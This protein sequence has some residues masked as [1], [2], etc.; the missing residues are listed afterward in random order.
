MKRQVRKGLPLF[1]IIPFKT[2]RKIMKS[3]GVRISSLRSLKILILALLP[4]VLTAQ[5]STPEDPPELILLIRA[6]EQ[7]PNPAELVD[8]VER[9]SGLPE[10]MDVGDPIGGK[11][12]LPR[13]G[14]PA[15]FRGIATTSPDSPEGRLGR[16]IVFEYPPTADFAMIAAT[17]R[18]HPHVEHVE[19]NR[20]ITLSS[21]PVGATQRAL[22]SDPLL[23][24]A[25]SDPT[26]FQ[27]GTH[28][29]NLP[30]AWDLTTGHATIGLLDLGLQPD[31]PDLRTYGEA[32]GGGLLFE[33]GNFREHRSQDVFFDDCNVDE[34]DPNDDGSETNRAGH[35]THVAG[36]AAATTDNREGIAGSCPGCGLHVMKVFSRGSSSTVQT[37][38]GL[39]QLLAQGAQIASMS[40]GIDETPCQGAS[41]LR[42]LCQFIA[43]ANRRGML[44]IASSG[45]DR[46]GVEFPAN[47]EAVV[48][49][50]GASYDVGGFR[51]WDFCPSG[52]PSDPNCICPLSGVPG[53]DEFIECGSNFGPEQ[54][55][56]APA[57]TVLST[58]YTGTDHST[59][60]CGDT[61]LPDVPGYGPCTGT[62]MSAPYIA[63]IAG[64]VRSAN[65][66][67]TNEEVRDIL[68]A[69][70]SQGG[71]HSPELGYG[72]PNA[73]AAVQKALGTVGGVGLTNRLTPLF[74]LYAEVDQ[75]HAF[76]TAPTM[77]SALIFDEDSPFEPTGLEVPGYPFFPGAECVVSPC[78]IQPAAMVYIF[79]TARSPLS[80]T[81][82][83]VPLYR[84][85]YNPN[86]PNRCG[87]DPP[88][89]IPARDFG[90]TTTERG[91][92]HFKE[93][94]SD[95]EGNSYELDGIEGYIYERC[96]PEPACIP[97][98]AERLYRLYHP[99]RGDFALFL[100]TD[101]A[102]WQAQG[103]G[104]VSGLNSWL[105]YAYPAVDTDGDQLIDGFENLIGTDPA[106]P[107]SDCDG[108]ADG[109]ELLRYDV[110]IHSYGDPL[111]ESQCPEIFSDDFET[112]TPF[113]WSGWITP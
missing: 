21:R 94:F 74:G 64:L 24:P 17:L 90:Y 111:S 102:V 44:M 5:L 96:E 73:E 49:V 32:P 14:R 88:L 60:G 25:S 45:N 81:P 86:L 38:N 51:F 33:G 100:E 63:G 29:L 66:L 87:P 8:A 69:T 47:T 20:V 98:G 75:T 34:L 79:T 19:R 92:L 97:P 10:G 85:V 46:T 52:N 4:T 53:F 99:G 23:S 27:W 7:H 31:H 56:V 65:P 113:R 18:D 1:L 26:E 106:T 54:E 76:V 40:F 22:T 48:A 36:L 82:P 28:A 103:Y 35:G 67:L 80:G 77:A 83:L 70:A 2:M 72:L 95:N 11:V 109:V 104:E 58:V 108:V 13:A 15:P 57:E 110:S 16:Y 91:I 89:H 9:G 59:L 105:G 55:L 112:G 41:D 30:A 37:S 101:L 61:F 3:R 39:E 68:A 107:D 71:V 6:G 62:S 84:M 78:S 42:L 12:A 93:Q 43:S 50:G